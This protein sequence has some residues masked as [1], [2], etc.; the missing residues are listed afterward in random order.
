MSEKLSKLPISAKLARRAGV[1]VLAATSLF[2]MNAPRANATPA[3][4]VQTTPTEQPT[5]VAPGDGRVV[6]DGSDPVDTTTTTEQP[7]VVVEGDGR[8]V[9]DGS[10]TEVFVPAATDPVTTEQQADPVTSLPQSP[11]I[12]AE[13]GIPTTTV[14]EQQQPATQNNDPAVPAEVV[15]LGLGAAGAV[16]ATGIARHKH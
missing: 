15:A 4:R 5:D 3:E 6:K 7:T 16:V 14:A 11:A 1:L 2:G 13:S 8:V 9:K 10:D 12:S